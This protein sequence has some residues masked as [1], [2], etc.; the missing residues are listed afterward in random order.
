M[1]L[2]QAFLDW[3]QA[4]RQEGQRSP[5]ILQIEQLLDSFLKSNAIAYHF[6]T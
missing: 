4:T 1:A 6:S 5:I 3:K 2:S